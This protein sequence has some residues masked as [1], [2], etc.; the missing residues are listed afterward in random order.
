MI[1]GLVVTLPADT[2]LLARALEA[3]R[4]EPALELGTQHGLRLPLVLE[5]DTS[6]ES[7][8]LTDWL[9]QLPGV[10]HV[11]VAYV[12]LEPSAV[13]AEPSAGVMHSP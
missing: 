6:T 4:Q 7:Q 9:Q 2:Q 3:I 12:H 8:T 5:T 10:Q 13:D 1:S 11:D